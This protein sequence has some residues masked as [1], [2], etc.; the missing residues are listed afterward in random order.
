[1]AE[2]PTVPSHLEDAEEEAPSV[3]LSKL[4]EVMT[5]R[6][7]RLLA[8]QNERSTKLFNNLFDERLQR[9]GSSGG[10]THGLGRDSR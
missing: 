1:M 10:C 9:P 8:E 7:E 4:M 5:K 2:Q 3:S 6:L